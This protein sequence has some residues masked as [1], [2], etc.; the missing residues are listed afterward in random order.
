[1]KISN[2]YL[3]DLELGWRDVTE[4]MGQKYLKALK[5]VAR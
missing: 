2:A 5:K 4:V 3:C 1:M